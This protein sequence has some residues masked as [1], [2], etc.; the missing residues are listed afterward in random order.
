MVNYMLHVHKSPN[1]VESTASLRVVAGH[2]AGAPAELQTVST[3]WPVDI[4]GVAD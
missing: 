4:K 1:F 3:R 2:E